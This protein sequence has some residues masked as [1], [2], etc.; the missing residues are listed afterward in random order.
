MTVEAVIFDL[1]NT[2]VNRK[3]A[4]MKYSEWFIDQ[5]VI[6]TDILHKNEVLEYIRVADRDGYRKKHELYEE[7]LTTLPMKN[8]EITVKDL[9]EPWFSEFYKHT[10]LMDGAFEILDY[11]KQMDIKLGLITNGSVHTQNSKIDQVMLRSYFDTIIV[12]DEVKLKKPD[13]RIF[14]LALERLNVNPRESW[15]VG[16]HPINDI[17]GAVDAGLNAIWLKGFMD[18]GENIEEPKYIIDHL[19]VIKEV[20]E[21]VSHK[22]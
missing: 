14:E 6:I 7:L 16:D 15:Y 13:K 9:L 3:H 8:S 19:N 20:L 18:W 21:E 5:F 4:F 11:L 10:V 12:S 1:D 2:L 17:Q 22:Q